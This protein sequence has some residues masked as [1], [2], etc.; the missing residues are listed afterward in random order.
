[1]PLLPSNFESNSLSGTVKVSGGAANI[2]L[3]VSKFAFEGDKS[4]VL[5][6]RRNSFDGPILAT[7]NVITL[8]DRS[9]IISLTA[10]TSTVAEGNLVSLSL[11]TAN[12]VNGANVFFSIFP[13]TANITP[14]DFFGS[15]T[16]IVTINDNQGTVVLQANADYSIVDETGEAFRVQIRTVNPQGNVVFVSSNIAITDFYKRINVFGFTESA[17]TISEGTSVTFTVSAHN[18]ASGT[19]LYYYTSGNTSF[20]GSNTGSIA[21]NSVSNTIT[22]T[23]S[24]AI[25]LNETRVFNL[26][27]S[28]RDLGTPIAVSNTITVADLAL[29]TITATGGN[30]VVDGGY[31]IHTFTTS[32]NLTI[33]GTSSVTQLEYLAVAGGGGGGG[34]ASPLNLFTGGGGGGGGLLFGTLSASSAGNTVIVVGAGGGSS[35]NGSNTLL[36]TLLAVGG[37]AGSGNPGPISASLKNGGS[38]GGAGANPAGS[39]ISGQGNPGG[40]GS[41]QG[42]GGGGGYSTR[43]G[44]AVSTLGGSGGFGYRSTISGADVGYA[45]GGGGGTASPTGSPLGYDGG[46]NG[47][48]YIAAGG[49]A[50]NVNS[51]GGGGGMAYPN[52]SVGGAAGG[53]GIVIIRYPWQPL[54]FYSSLTANVSAA[55]H[56]SNVSFVL[57]SVFANSVTLYYDTVGNV[58]TSNFVNGNTGSFTISSNSTVLSLSTL[59]NI[60][61]DESRVFQLRLREDS[62]TGNILFVSSNILLLTSNAGVISATGGNVTLIE[63]YKVHT[64]TTSDSLVITSNGIGSLN[65]VEYLAVA[66]G[67]G[68][69]SGD[70]VGRNGAGGGAGGLILGTTSLNISTY[71]IAIGAGGAGGAIGGPQFTGGV[72]GVQGSNTGI[73]SNAFIAVGGGFGG[74]GRSG[75]AR[76]GGPG[77]SGGGGQETSGGAGFGFPSPTQQGYP[78]GGGPAAYGGGGAGQAGSSPGGVGANIAISGIMTTYAGGGGGGGGS[79]GLGGVGGG[80][81][82]GAAS[83]A[84]I[85]GTPGVI[86]TGGGGGGGNT[87]SPV[88]PSPAG[89]GGAGGSGIVIIRYPFF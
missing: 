60:P 72:P 63:G 30:V 3:A 17:S 2:S 8:I 23:A 1:M 32:G 6:L 48:R 14:S 57:N 31:K 21:M 87:R 35:T 88:S 34:A 78:G 80:G 71:A 55:L 18:I 39:G 40:T 22:L 13:A 28:E 81:R 38:G 84:A 79:G 11:V 68:G 36:G 12:V 50:G 77:G 75:S 65:T 45:G 33:T 67:G 42:S 74:G 19:L 16:G 43:G 82:G 26:L 76:A 59:A 54:P 58:T 15:N 44:N 53:G 25:P 64:F 83:P 47:Y 66:G 24:P 10:N 73:F 46:G 62:S 5:K 56:G 9:E 86:N 51:G 85:P 41:N 27:L 69:G 37:G 70:A 61:T 89:L 4:F 52:G 20:V 29:T 49:A 7:S